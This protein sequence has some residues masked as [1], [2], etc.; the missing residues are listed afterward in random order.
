MLEGLSATAPQDVSPVCGVAL[1]LVEKGDVAAAA[2][3]Y[4]KARQ[5]FQQY[6]TRQTS[7]GM[8]L[9]EQCAQSISRNV[10]VE[11]QVRDVLTA[12]QS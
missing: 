9:L 3:H 10:S 12:P 6:P 1:V 7:E 2:E 8:G 11:P 5:L 4:W